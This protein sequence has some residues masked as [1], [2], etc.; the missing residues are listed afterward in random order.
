MSLKTETSIW[1]I[2]YW[3]DPHHMKQFP[4]IYIQFPLLMLH[5]IM[6]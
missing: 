4:L 3:D 2:M 5:S 6:D 1:I